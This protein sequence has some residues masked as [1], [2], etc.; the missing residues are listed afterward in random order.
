MARFTARRAGWLVK[1]LNGFAGFP[2]GCRRAVWGLTYSFCHFLHSFINLAVELTC[3]DGANFG[4]ADKTENAYESGSYLLNG[5]PSKLLN[6]GL[7]NF[8]PGAEG[9]A[10]R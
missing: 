10:A 7:C 8:G 5:Q 9:A 3:L 6:S 4:I 2:F 1:K